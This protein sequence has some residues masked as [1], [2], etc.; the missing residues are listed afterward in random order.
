MKNNQLYEA[1]DIGLPTVKGVY[2]CMCRKING[3]LVLI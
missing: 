3:D 2:W 1:H